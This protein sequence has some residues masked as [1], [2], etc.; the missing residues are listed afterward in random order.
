MQGVKFNFTDA[1]VAWLTAN[2]AD[3]KN[4]ELCEELGCGGSTLH[5]WA[6]QLGLTKSREH[7]ERTNL[8]ALE[9]AWEHNRIFGNSGNANIIELGKPYRYKKGVRPI[10]RHGAEGEA[11]RKAKLS[12]TR[13][14]MIR[15]ERLRIKWGLP[16]RTKIRFVFDHDHNQVMMRHNFKRHG[17]IVTRGARVIYWDENTKRS[18]IMERNASK[19]GLIVKQ[20]ER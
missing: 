9:A 5:R 19:K 14:K 1:Q 17:Y 13:Q 12:E 2:Y 3:M 16:Q 20:I 7:M 6:R 11:R 8:N 10:D 4:A 15:S 18:A